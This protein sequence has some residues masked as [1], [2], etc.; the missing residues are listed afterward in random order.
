MILDKIEKAARK[1]GALILNAGRPEA[2]KKEGHYNFVTETDIR[3]QELL[4]AE[5]SEILPEA[6]F[7]AE[8]KT[9][10]PLTEAYTW[11]VDPIDGTL[12]FMH[13]R[14][15]SAISVALLKDRVPVAGLIYN[16]FCN[17]VFSAEKGKGARL[18]GQPIHVSEYPFE[19][20]MVAMGTAPYEPALL[21]VTMKAA[22]AFLSQA[23][24]LRRTGSAAVDLCDVACGRCELFFEYQL[25]PWDIAAGSL[26]VQEAGGA[27]VEFLE[28]ALTFDKKVAVLASNR[29]CLEPALRI[30]QDQ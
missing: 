16:P 17:E 11:V 19:N 7:Y 18:N 1:A 5:L 30:L 27:F 29:T 22:S 6:V 20:A 13:H 28:P 26:I 15:C 2:Y 8:E 24:D 25:A 12:N 4:H 23:G 9:N 10:D 14:N 21:P 3:V